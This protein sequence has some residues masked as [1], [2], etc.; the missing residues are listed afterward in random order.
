MLRGNLTKRL[1]DIREELTRSR[2]A[3]R[4]LDEQVA[5]QQGV[6]DDAATAAVV[7][8]TPLANRE[9]REAGGDLQRLRRERDD[10][11]QCIAAL[12]AEQDQILEQLFE[13]AGGP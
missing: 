9:R 3:V 4:I 6:A 11:R 13:Q 5:F 7:E 2:E 8:E 12:V 10:L 1:E